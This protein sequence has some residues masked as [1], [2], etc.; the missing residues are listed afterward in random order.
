MSP[1]HFC[2]SSIPSH[3]LF[4]SPPFLPA[5]EKLMLFVMMFCPPPASVYSLT[6]P[7]THQPLASISCFSVDHPKA[8]KEDCFHNLYS[9]PVTS[10]DS[11]ES[12][13]KEV[14]LDPHSVLPLL[15]LSRLVF[16]TLPSFP[17]RCSLYS[18]FQYSSFCT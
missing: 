13:D 8:T 12:L 10:S 6:P 2:T 7:P 4:F 18:T 17:Q 5:P 3:S 16:L 14:S 15:P 11:L 1:S 9:T